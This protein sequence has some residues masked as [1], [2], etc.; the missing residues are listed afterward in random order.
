MFS[1]RHFFI[2]CLFS[3]LCHASADNS[4]V[5][6]N[7]EAENN[8]EVEN[9]NQHTMYEIKETFGRQ[10]QVN[11]STAPSQMP[12][13]VPSHMPSVA[14]IIVLTQVNGTKIAKRIMFDVTATE[15]VT[16]ESFKIHIGEKLKLDA[17]MKGVQLWTKSGTH[18]GSETSRRNWSRLR[19]GSFQNKGN[20]NYTD[21]GFSFSQFT[22]VEIPADTTRGFY[23][24]FRKG[25]YTSE[26]TAI[27]EVSSQ[28]N[29]YIDIKEGTVLKSPRTVEESYVGLWNGGMVLKPGI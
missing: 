28:P 3:T 9:A 16:V 26:G 15:D 5:E 2:F 11:V 4:F 12:S 10:L 1:F 8:G 19:M 22:K 7:V 20:G 23:F 21:I 27:G 6:N 14:P 18:V 24:I 29:S 25:F 13:L 17:I